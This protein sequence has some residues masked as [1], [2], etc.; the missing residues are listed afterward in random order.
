MAK[1]YTENVRP[2]KKIKLPVY[3]LFSKT[4]P[5]FHFAESVLWGIF[6]KAMTFQIHEGR[7]GNL[8]IYK[9]KLSTC[10]P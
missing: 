10:F 9:D 4:W 3:S 7:E 8:H 6:F 1:K 2:E 5:L